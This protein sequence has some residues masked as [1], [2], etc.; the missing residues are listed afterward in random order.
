MRPSALER[1]NSLFLNISSKTHLF[2][3][4]FNFLYDHNRAKTHLCQFQFC[5]ISGKCFL[6]FF[7]KTKTSLLFSN[8]ILIVYS[9]IFSGRVQNETVSLY[10]YDS[11]S[12]ADYYDRNFLPVFVD[13]YKDK[14]LEL[15]NNN[16]TLFKEAN[17]VCY[18]V[19][20]LLSYRYNKYNNSCLHSKCLVLLSM[21][22]Y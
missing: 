5:L 15:F 6:S 14:L 7:L 19:F 20:Q 2:L 17:Q 1:V 8:S 16:E 22:T 4:G 21:S 13:E 12:I 10:E 18:M 11:G 9:D 3:A